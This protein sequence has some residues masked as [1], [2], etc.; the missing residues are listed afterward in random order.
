MPRH[1][2][3]LTG[4]YLEHLL[5]RASVSSNARKNGQP[6]FLSFSVSTI[7]FIYAFANIMI[8]SFAVTVV[9][10]TRPRRLLAEMVFFPHIV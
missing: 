10:G 3:R 9:I 5:L 2:S 1:H 8:G 4:E 7:N 6:T